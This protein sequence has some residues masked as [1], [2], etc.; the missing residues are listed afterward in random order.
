MVRKAASSENKSLSDWVRGLIRERVAK[1][2]ISLE[3]DP[4][5]TLSSLMLPAPAI[6]EMLK[7]I[8]AGRS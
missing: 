6:D 7:E 2:K 1:R 4:I 5:Q 8:E 3:G